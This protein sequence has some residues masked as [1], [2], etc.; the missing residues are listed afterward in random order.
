MIVGK[1]VAAIP[2]ALLDDDLVAQLL[3]ELVARRGRLAPELHRGPVGADRIDA[4][5][6]LW[7]VDPGDAV[8]IGKTHVVVVE[9]T[10]AEDVL[11]CVVSH[12]FEGTRYKNAIF[13]L[14][15]I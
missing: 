11:L 1:Q 4:R 6:Q 2:V 7:R 8:E 10:I 12:E 9:V 5:R 14:D 15:R 3:D 13:V